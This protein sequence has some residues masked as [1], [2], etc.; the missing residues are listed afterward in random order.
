MVGLAAALGA[1]AHALM[2][3]PHPCV[4]IGMQGFSGVTNTPIATLD[5]GSALTGHFAL[6]AP[7]MLVCGVG[8]VLFQRSAIYIQL[9]S[10]QID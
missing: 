4:I 10:G 9:V 3:D 5:T 2:A 8:M 6:L 7:L 1:I